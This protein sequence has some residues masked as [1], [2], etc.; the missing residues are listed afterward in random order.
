MATGEGYPEKYS[1]GG[2]EVG[3]TARTHFVWMKFNLHSTWLRGKDILR[4]TV[5]EEMRLV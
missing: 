2:D 3:V 4:S 5:G 1:G